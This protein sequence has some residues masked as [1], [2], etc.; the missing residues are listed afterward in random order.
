[1]DL[2]VD[3]SFEREVLNRLGI[4]ASGRPSMYFELAYSVVLI[5]FGYSVR[6]EV[7]D[8]DYLPMVNSVAHT[9]TGSAAASLLLLRDSTRWYTSPRRRFL[10]PLDKESVF[11]DV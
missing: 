7:K 5:T 1:M 11:R 3:A 2:A 4:E 6:N 10:C 9:T 8:V